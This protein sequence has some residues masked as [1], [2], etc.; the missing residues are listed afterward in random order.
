MNRGSVDDIVCVITTFGVVRVSRDRLVI[1]INLLHNRNLFLSFGKEFSSG[2]QVGRCWWQGNWDGLYKNKS[3]FS[4]R[5]MQLA[6]DGY[7]ICL[8]V[9]LPV[10]AIL[11]TYSRG[12]EPGFTR[13][14]A[15]RPQ[16]PS[17]AECGVSRSGWFS[18]KS[19]HI[20]NWNL[21]FTQQHEEALPCDKTR[22]VISEKPDCLMGDCNF[23]WAIRWWVTPGRRPAAVHRCHYHKMNYYG[24]FWGHP[25]VVDIDRGFRSWTWCLDTKSYRLEGI[26][27]DPENGNALFLR[28]V[29]LHSWGYEFISSARF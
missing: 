23:I 2:Q 25:I 13:H 21:F 6:D 14:M 3:I 9:T 1:L 24:N 15:A 18:A 28:Y 8:E 5:V 11:E 19:C 10:A 20:S 17:P 26:G 27:L 12:C 7:R 29:T 22:N 4:C 16:P